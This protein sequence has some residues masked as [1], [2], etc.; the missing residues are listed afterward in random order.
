M[1]QCS[2]TAA[3][4]CTRPPGDGQSRPALGSRAPRPAPF[5]SSAL[6]DPLGL[7]PVTARQSIV[8]KARAIQGHAGDR[9][10]SAGLEEGWVGHEGPA[11]AR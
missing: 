9:R 7:D 5:P 1:T 11:R 4:H 3:R 6:L 2:P 8:A 10:Q